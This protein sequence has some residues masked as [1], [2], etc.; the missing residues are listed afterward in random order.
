MYIENVANV[1]TSFL[2]ICCQQILFHLSQITTRPHTIRLKESKYDRK[3]HR[4]S[5]NEFEKLCQGSLCEAFR[6]LQSSTNT[7]ILEIS[8]SAILGQKSSVG[9]GVKQKRSTIRSLDRLE[10]AIKKSYVSKNSFRENKAEPMDERKSLTTTLSLPNTFLLASNLVHQ[11]CQPIFRSSM[12]LR[13]FR[14]HRNIESQLTRNPSF[15]SRI[16]QSF[17]KNFTSFF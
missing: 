5:Q 4:S 3:P 9:L 6:N 17:G 16:Q 8:I 2:F 10:V 14:T 12:Q 1:F 15:L 7:S 11:L 13:G